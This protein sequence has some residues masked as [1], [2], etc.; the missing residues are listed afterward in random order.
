MKKNKT[1]AQQWTLILLWA[2]L[3]T[4]VAAACGPATPENNTASDETD[5]SEETTAETDN[6]EEATDETDNNE[7]GSHVTASGLEYI[8]IEAG[9]GSQAQ[10][11]DQVSVHYTGTLED[12][13]EFDSSIGGE[14]LP[15]VL[16]EGRVIPGWEEGIALM[17][18]GGKATLIIPPELGYGAAGGGPIPPNATLHFDVE[19]VATEPVPT[20]APPPTSAPPTFVDPADFTT[21]ESGLQYYFLEEGDGATPLLGEVASISFTGWLEDGQKFGDSQGGVPIQFIVGEEQIV[22]G[23]DEMVLLMQIGDVVQI[24]LPPE[25]GLGEAGSPN[26]TI[27]PNATL[28]F[29]MEL[30]SIEPPPPTP[31]PAPPPTSI[32]ESEFLVTDSGLKFFI[33]TDGSGDLIELGDLVTAHYIMWLEDGTQLETSYDF[34]QPIQLAVGEVQAGPGWDEAMLMMNVG[35]KAQ[36]ILTPEL[37]YGSQAANGPTEGDLVFEL[38]IIDVVKS[39]SEE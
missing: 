17:R 31:T 37:A 6:S 7:T 22:P 9:T 20:P 30:V 26:G 34:G 32:E 39:F 23:W 11:G 36:F 35:S 10:I 16:G 38:E 2:V 33:I 14:P 29:E 15:F 18:V 25:L 5:S 4:L 13:T 1:V 21:T 3:L 27:P 28:I 12:G 24:I 8:E 19:L